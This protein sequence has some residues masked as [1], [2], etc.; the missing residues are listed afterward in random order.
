MADS[1]KDKDKVSGK[2]KK[3]AKAKRRDGFESD[4]NSSANEPHHN[5]SAAG[6]A[7]EGEGRERSFST[8]V[9]QVVVPVTPEQKAAVRLQSLFRGH[10]F[11]VEYQRLS[12]FRNFIQLINLIFT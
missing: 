10:V 3:L 1:N 9:V 5:G 7:S 11:R 6:S 2:E 8:T 4:D 12:T